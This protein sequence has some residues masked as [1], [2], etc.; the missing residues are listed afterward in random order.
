MGSEDLAMTR[1][2]SIEPLKAA[3]GA[4]VLGLDPGQPPNRTEQRELFQAL[5]SHHLLIFDAGQLSPAALVRF[6]SL[7]G[8][9][10]IE[11]YDNMQLEGHPAIM[12]VGNVG[13]VLEQEAFRNGAAFWHTDR[14]YAADC[15]AVTMLHCL[16]APAEGGETHFA[17]LQAA[18]DALEPDEKSRL[19]DLFALH[20][21]GAG[22]REDWEMSVHPMSA[23]QAGQLPPPGRHPLA[24]AHSVTGRTGLYAISGSGI[25]VQR[26]T[27]ALPREEGENLLRALKLHAI[28]ERF[29]YR[30]RY[31]PG[32]LVLWD[33][34]ATLHYATPV[35]PPRDSASSRLLYRVVAMGLPAPLQS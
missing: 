12:Q 13:P 22:G 2:L 29:V 17:N 9:P 18:Y 25:A 8:K 31:Q 19:Q 14:A 23:D 35:G 16:M 28:E 27:D 20:R 32:D 11:T 30:H 3:L 15:N 1:R 21:Y 24:R 26:G 34:T 33:N 7:W 5:Y 4:R 10:Y 6:A